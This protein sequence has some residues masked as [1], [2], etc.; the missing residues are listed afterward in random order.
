MFHKQPICINATTQK[1]R[2]L[3]PS[4]F[5]ELTALQGKLMFAQHISILSEI[6]KS[7]IIVV[8][9]GDYFITFFYPLLFLYQLLGSVSMFIFRV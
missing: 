8:I 4:Y 6:G 3:S 2:V 5:F 1:G 7:F 9:L